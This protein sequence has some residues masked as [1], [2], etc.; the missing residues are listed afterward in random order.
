METTIIKVTFFESPDGGNRKEF[1]YG[2]L[3][4]IYDDFSPEQIGCKL[5]TLWRSK[6]TCNK[7][8]TGRKCII[9]KHILQHK[10][11]KS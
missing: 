7:P 10:Q 5:S 9:S 4:A 1:Y 6:I 2:S 3:S 8:Y 11:N